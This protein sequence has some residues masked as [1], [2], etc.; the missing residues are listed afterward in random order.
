MENRRG[1]ISFLFILLIFAISVIAYIGYENDIFTREHIDI[2]VCEDKISWSF[3]NDRG[4]DGGHFELYKDDLEIYRGYDFEYENPSLIDTASPETIEDIEVD[5]YREK[6]VLNWNE[7]LDRGSD[8]TFKVYFVNKYGLRTLKSQAYTYNYISGIDKYI[9]KIADNLFETIEN[10]L[11]IEN[12]E[13]D[14]GIHKISILTYDSEGNESDPFEEVTIRNIVLDLEEDDDIFTIINSDT[15]QDYTYMVHI[16]NEIIPVQGSSIRHMDI[17]K[18]I[19]EFE[20]P[21][22]NKGL[23]ADDFVEFSW[24]TPK[25]ER[26]SYNYYIEGIGSKYGNRV[27][28]PDFSRT[29]R[30][31]GYYYDV[32]QIEEYEISR[33]DRCIDPYDRFI[34]LI[35]LDYEQNKLELAEDD[36]A[37]LVGM[38]GIEF[39][40][41]YRPYYIHIALMDNCSNLSETFT[42]ELYLPSKEKLEI[43]ET[44]FKLREPIY[45]KYDLEKRHVAMLPMNIINFIKEHN[46]KIYLNDDDLGYI[47]DIKTGEKT[48]AKAIG[49]YYGHNNTILIDSKMYNQMVVLHEVGHSIDYVLSKGS[50][51]STKRDFVNIY[52]QEKDKLYK[53]SEYYRREPQEY[54]AEAFSDYIKEP[55]KVKHIA[56]LTYEYMRNLIE[57]IE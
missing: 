38:S 42:Y 31:S 54:F 56:P 52:R 43:A 24:G 22:L 23:F 47:Y 41:N 44:F 33:D 17:F 34:F 20:A 46:L 35:D 45:N 3:Q 29:S 11:D 27:Y 12:S 50:W 18:D 37:E 53:D 49:T 13:L 4:L 6:I 39:S 25:I 8:N 51:L 1:R 55:Y 48:D 19:P 21:I 15:A 26:I 14:P 40:G 28:S 7:P 2:V 36:G 10:K 5:Y 30:I 32:N 9:L 57:S 16:D